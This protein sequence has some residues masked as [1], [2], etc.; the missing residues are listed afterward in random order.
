MRTVP[1]LT[2]AIALAGLLAGC[3]DHTTAP[4]DVTPPAAPRGVTSVTGDQSVAVRWLANTESDVVGYRVYMSVCAGGPDCPYDRVG[5]TSAT[6]FS[7]QGLT[8]GAT[9]YFAVAAV[10]QAGNESP[11][12]PEDV[13]D[14]PRPRGQGLLTNALTSPSASGWDFS[15]ATALAWDAPATD[16]WFQSQNGLAVA[17]GAGLTDLQDAGYTYSFDEAGWSPVG[18]AAGWSPTRSVELIVGHTYYVWT[19]DDHY[20][21]FR[22]TGLSSALVSFEWGYQTARGNPE[23]HARRAGAVATIGNPPPSRR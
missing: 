16:I 5:S 8:N 22:V 11:L 10:D 15:S 19:R 6:S 2:A 13:F 20:A 1:R 17:F 21:K 7:V 9:R 4:R 23:L 3:E 14:T 18:T 12:S